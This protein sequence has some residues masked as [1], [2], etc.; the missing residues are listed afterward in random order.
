MTLLAKIIT[1]LLVTL[2]SFFVLSKK[3]PPPSVPIAPYSP[4]DSVITHG[5]R[6]K[7]VVALTFDADMTPKMKRDL[8]E[9]KVSSWYNKKVID[10]LETNKVPATLFLAGMWIE[11]YPKETKELS[12]NP[13][14]QLGNHSYSHPAFEKKC[15][16]LNLIPHEKDDEEI[17]KTQ[18]LLKD[19]AGIDNHIFR[20]P[21]GCYDD[22]AL[23]EVHKLGLDAIG[24]DVTSSD[25]FNP[26][27]PQLVSNVLNHAQ[28]GSIILMHMIGNRNA[29]QTANALPTIISGLKARGFGFVKVSEITK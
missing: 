4:R 3:V 15:T 5:S 21:G 7:K 14:F 25:A 28:N 29:P 19:V 18:K 16:A 13:L 8:E 10:I 6:D 12:A 1:L 11:L 2:T 22:F 23:K 17:E 26:N 24:W 27:E 20:F 9:G